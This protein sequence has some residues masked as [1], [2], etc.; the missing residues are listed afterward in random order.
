[1]EVE[2]WRETLGDRI[3]EIGEECMQERNACVCVIERERE[4]KRL[5]FGQF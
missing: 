2:G 1:M 5:S 4:R 3:R